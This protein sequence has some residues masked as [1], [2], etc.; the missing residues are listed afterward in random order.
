MGQYL[1]G[2]MSGTAALDFGDVPTPEA[3][4]D[5]TGIP[6]ISATSRVVI[7]LQGGDAM[8]SNSEVDHRLAAESI[9]FTAGAVVP[10]VGFP[11][12]ASSNFAFWTGRFRIHW[13]WF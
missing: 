5:V 8:S 12:Y 7:W 3:S 4:V 1:Q 11:I 10:G 6:E 2:P 13:R 9:S